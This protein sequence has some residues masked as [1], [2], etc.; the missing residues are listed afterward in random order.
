ML[1]LYNVFALSWFGWLCFKF[2]VQADT[3]KVLAS[4][5]NM[6]IMYLWIQCVSRILHFAPISW[7]YVLPQFLICAVFEEQYGYLLHR[8]MH[9]NKVLFRHVHTRHHETKTECWIT[10]FYVH[11]LELVSFYFLGLAGGPLLLSATYGLS[12]TAYTLWLCGATFFLSWSHTGQDLPYMPSTKFHAL[13]HRYYNCNFG[14]ATIDWLFD[15]DRYT[16]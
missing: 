10:A 2:G 8:Y 3:S 9:Q 1:A 16:D 11:P 13:H 14:S 5:P 12:Y 4:I 15:T 6:I 7:L